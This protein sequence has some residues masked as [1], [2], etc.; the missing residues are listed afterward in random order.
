MNKIDLLLHQFKITFEREDWFPHL[1]M[2]L[3][4]V[5]AEQ[6]K[7]SPEGEAGNTIWGIVNHLIYYKERFLQLLQGEKPDFSAQNNTA[8]FDLDE[9]TEE[10]WQATLQRLQ[11]I[12]NGFVQ[13]LKTKTEDDFEKPLLKTSNTGLTIQSILLHDAYHTG[14]IVLLRKLQG[15]WPAT[16][17][18]G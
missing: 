11:D 8:T 18:F 4:G 12:H 9:S 10:Q 13:Y 15:S 16:R 6:A 14:Q 3:N 1:Q 17:N 7:W 5:T 2:A